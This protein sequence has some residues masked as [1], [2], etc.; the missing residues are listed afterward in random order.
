MGAPRQFFVGMQRTCKRGHRYVV[1][2]KMAKRY[3]Y[4]CKK[5]ASV[6]AVAYARNNRLKKRKWNRDYAK[7]HRKDCSITRKYRRK[8]P[9][10]YHAHQAVN[11]AIKNGSL[12]RKPCQ[13]CGKRKV[14]GH[15]EDYKQPLKVEWLCHQH[16]MDRHWQD[17]KLREL[18]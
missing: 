10:R 14:H 9:E 1:T 8:Y 16:H 3:N 18:A 17:G 11:H 15:H 7:R 6:R 13:V 4:E 2:R 12:K 5:C